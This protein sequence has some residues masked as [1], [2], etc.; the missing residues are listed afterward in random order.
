MYQHYRVIIVSIILL[1]IGGLIGPQSITAQTE[2]QKKIEA[3]EKKTEEIFLDFSS[4]TVK[5]SG[6]HL[7]AKGYFE[8]DR[9]FVYNTKF[10]NLKPPIQAEARRLGYKEG[11][12]VV[13]LID[14][15][16][17]T[18]ILTPLKSKEWE[19]NQAFWVTELIEEDGYTAVYFSIDESVVKLPWKVSSKSVFLLTT[20]GD[21][22]H[23]CGLT[24][25]NGAWISDDIDN[26]QLEKTDGAYSLMNIGEGIPLTFRTFTKLRGGKERAISMV[27][28]T[29]GGN[30]NRLVIQGVGSA[31]FDAKHFGY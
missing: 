22:I 4:V 30:P 1:L 18:H 15:T 6:A 28:H 2:M 13:V 25:K 20:E 23:W 5:K 8:I 12:T 21:S 3:V 7:T 19:Q 17:L 31:K 10:D 24:T 27:F 16:P 14:T 26:M 29:L 11:D 9:E